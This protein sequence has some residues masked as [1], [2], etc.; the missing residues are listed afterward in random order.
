METGSS[1]LFVFLI[2][3]IFIQIYIER[4]LRDSFPSLFLHQRETLLAKEGGKDH[5]NIL[6]SLEFFMKKK[7]KIKSTEMEKLSPLEAYIYLSPPPL[8][9]S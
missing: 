1:I 3:S 5:S 8:L 9:A 2:L 7:K 6:A 4:D